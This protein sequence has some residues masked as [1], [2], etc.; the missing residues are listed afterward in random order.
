MKTTIYLRDDLAQKVKD[1]LEAH[2]GKTLSNLVQE[3]LEAKIV[4]ANG[5]AEI[6]KLAG[7]VESGES[8]DS[9]TWCE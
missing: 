6:L 2:P 8:N 1:Y 3:A 4:R 5:A 9:E 7:I